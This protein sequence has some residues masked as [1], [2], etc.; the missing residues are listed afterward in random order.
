MA[1]EASAFVRNLEKGDA[2]EA[3]MF[4]EQ[5]SDVYSLG[6]ALFSSV[7]L[8]HPFDSQLADNAQ[9][10]QLHFDKKEFD[11]FWQDSDLTQMLSFIKKTFPSEN[12]AEF[13]DLLEKMLETDPEQRLSIKAVLQHPWFGNPSFFSLERRACSIFF[14]RHCLLATFREERGDS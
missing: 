8:K 4:D 5:K 6:L 12:L 7:F 13:K 2:G 14:R 1:P 11:L 10:Q 9:E 3:K